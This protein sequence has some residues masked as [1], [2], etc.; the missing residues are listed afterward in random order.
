MKRT[1]SLV[2][3]SCLLGGNVAIHD[4]ENLYTRLDVLGER[5]EE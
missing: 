1:E 4:I 2:I 5:Q 3:D